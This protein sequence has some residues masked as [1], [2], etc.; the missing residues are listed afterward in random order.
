MR[1]VALATSLAAG[2]VLA[3]STLVGTPA[4]KADAEPSPLQVSIDTVAPGY[5]PA[6]GNLV[7][8]G[9]V[10]NRSSTA[11]VGIAVR[12]RI[13]TWTLTSREQ[14]AQ[15]DSVADELTPD[16]ASLTVSEG[17]VIGVPI[18]VEPTLVAQV[19]MPGAQASFRIAIPAD[20]L[21]L[22]ANGVYT[23]GVEALSG[24]SGDAAAAESAGVDRVLVPWIDPTSG[25]QP[26]TLVWLWPVAAWP[27]QDSN[28]VLLDTTTP[29]E[30]ATG[31]RL[32][33]IVDLGGDSPVPVTWIVDPQSLQIA[34]EMTTGYRVLVDGAI[35]PGDD[36]GAAAAWLSSLQ[37]ALRGRGAAA[38]VDVPVRV[39]PYADVDIAA[40]QRAGLER[41]IVRSLATAPVLARGPL[42]R[43]P[44]GLVVMAPGGNL[45]QPS[46]DL[47]AT[48]GVN[49][50]ILS[51]AAMPPSP[52]VPFTPSGSASIPTSTGSMRVVLTDP[53]LSHIV[54]ATPTSASQVTHLEQRFLSETALVSLQLPGSA[55]TIVAA[56]SSARWDPTDVLI[57]RLLDRSRR[58]PWI[59]PGTFSDIVD[60]LPSSV[61]RQ[62]AAFSERERSAE[63]GRQYLA[64]AAETQA[65]LASLAGI[66]EDPVDLVESVSMT[67]LRTESS[68]WREQRNVGEQ[69]MRRTSGRVTADIDAVRILSRNT[70]TLSGEA[71]DIPITIANDLGQR[72]TVQLDVTASPAARLSVEPIPPVTVEPGRK[73]SIEVRAKVIGGG[74]VPVTLQLR[75]TEGEAF[76]QAVSVELRSTAYARAATWVVVAALGVIALFVVVGIIRRIRR[77]PPTGTP[78]TTPAAQGAS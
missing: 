59:T 41:D 78:S 7:L 47:L 6:T 33:R 39:L 54:D 56:P 3:L 5:V 68:A 70:I 14:I 51:A 45:E 12:L 25:V 8:S 58:T 15:V 40:L 62:H 42:G 53:A 10:G 71:G 19:L 36:P 46:I 61:P 75:T 43:R 13:G 66:L 23:V 72:I 11:L 73:M 63:L 67:L 29:Q 16:L 60:S 18:A 17:Q 37:Q 64:R 34:Q 74:P 65:R 9:R 48:S 26:T 38:N 1:P 30:F 69:L 57:T 55:R 2:L 24:Y 22:P 20:V 52:P 49:A 50:L 31:G 77:T 35:V 28:G 32:R 44:T 76:G 27:A 21:P 4:A